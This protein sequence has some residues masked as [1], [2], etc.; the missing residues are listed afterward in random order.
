V[1]CP[2]PFRADLHCHTTYS[3]GSFTP[4]ELILH[5]KKIG[6]SG[7][8]IT[9]HDTVAAYG[10]AQAVAARE[11]L[12][13][14]TGVEFS[15]YEGEVSVH[16]LG[17][18]IDLQALE[19]K[20]LCLRHESRRLERNRSILKKLEER[21][22]PLEENLPTQGSVIG[23]VHIATAMIKK[24]YVKSYKEAFNRFLGEGKPCYV[25][26]PH[27]SVE[28]TIAAIHAANG[29]AFI[30]HPQLLGE[31]KILRTLLEKPFDGLECYYCRSLPQQEKRLLK[32]AKERGL[33]FSGG[34]DFHGVFRQEAPL[35]CSWVDEET[36]RKIFSRNIC[37]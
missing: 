34:S 16:I 10:V 11:G 4:E 33:L 25:P 27:I 3:D 21:R 30:A 22:M 26:G 29:K 28:E 5:A 9:D 35:G 17:Y 23:R 37:C 15:A 13:L 7:L 14:G 32:I 20:Q 19:L 36:F 1:S 8:S 12:L 31:G 2:L 24:G 18:D 6:L